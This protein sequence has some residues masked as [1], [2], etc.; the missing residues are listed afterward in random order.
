MSERLGPPGADG[1]PRRQKDRVFF[2]IFPDADAA[3]RI[4]RLAGELRRELGLQGDPLAIA[5]LHV[6]AFFV[7]GFF[8][9]L[10]QAQV[11]G[12]ASTY[13]T[14]GRWPLSSA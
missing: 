2:A 5:R 7:G 9:G 14:L 11:R 3:S 8:R 13:R 1:A 12:A 4:Q 6:T 10:P